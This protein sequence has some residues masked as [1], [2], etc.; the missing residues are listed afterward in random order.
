[1]NRWLKK[2]GYRFVLR[3]FTYPSEV[4]PN[5]K[6]PFTTW[7]ENKGVAPCYK[8]FILAL[9]LRGAKT[10]VL[11]T[12]AD[13]R[14]WLPGDNLYDDAVIV[15]FDMPAGDYD[16]EIAMLDPATRQPKIRLAIEGRRED[17]WYPLGVIKVGTRAQ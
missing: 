3:K 11:E 12:A 10:A 8:P 6:V 1:V 16:V 5:G 15:P 13:I 14:K 4:K 9:R 17:G 2:M 7:W